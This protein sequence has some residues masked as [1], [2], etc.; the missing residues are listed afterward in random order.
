[1]SNTTCKHCDAI[2]RP[3]FTRC[4][5][6]GELVPGAVLASDGE[7]LQRGLT[8]GL[9]RLYRATEIEGHA[10]GIGR[11]Y[12][13]KRDPHAVGINPA[14]RSRIEIGDVDAGEFG[15]I[16]VEHDQSADLLLLHGLK[17]HLADISRDLRGAVVST[18][19]AFARAATDQ[20]QSEQKSIIGFLVEAIARR[21][22]AIGAKLREIVQ[23]QRFTNV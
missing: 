23:G 22:D 19:A 11:G 20:E 16:M 3:H 17:V 6:C 7:L 4:L 12:L 13:A 10:L 2:I 1:M 21:H 9:D 8:M 14:G 15:R 18:S 5:A